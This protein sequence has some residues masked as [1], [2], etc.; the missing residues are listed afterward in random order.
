M[1]PRSVLLIGAYAFSTTAADYI[2]CLSPQTSVNCGNNWNGSTSVIW[3]FKEFSS[4]SQGL[5]FAVMNSGKM[6][7]LS[8]SGTKKQVVIPKG[9]TRIEQNAFAEI[10]HLTSVTLP[11]GLES[12][13]RK[14]FYHCKLTE[15]VIPDG[16]KI[17]EESAFEGCC[18]LESVRFPDS[19]TTIGDRAFEL[20]GLQTLI[21]P[22]N[23]TS[24]GA[25]AFAGN[26]FESVTIPG[27]LKMIPRGAFENCEKLKQV[28]ICEGIKEIDTQAFCMSN[29]LETLVLPN[30]FT[31]IRDGAFEGV[32]ALKSITIP[33]TVTS[34]GSDAFY[35]S[36]R[37]EEIT[38]LGTKAEWNA[39]SKKNNWLSECYLSVIHC[40]DGDIVYS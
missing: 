30:G 19:L 32:F 28:T 22:Q 20:C 31:T 14:A 8:Y 37:L 13:G 9:V 34:I 12:I 24:I 7:V 35:G 11:E 1:I 33:N 17:I 39:I 6:V 25:Y 36:Y 18:Y 16:V 2:C 40:T 26:E 38:Y 21:L 29:I 23:I 5:N 10:L 3:D 27:S 4:D 15:I